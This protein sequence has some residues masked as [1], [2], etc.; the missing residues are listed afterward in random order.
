MLQQTPVPIIDLCCREY[1]GLAVPDF[2]T[3]YVY[4]D[5]DNFGLDV[6]LD[7]LLGRQVKKEDGTEDETEDEDFE[8]FSAEALK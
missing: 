4:D 2:T 5:Y 7:G 6:G 3:D 1:Y 8:D